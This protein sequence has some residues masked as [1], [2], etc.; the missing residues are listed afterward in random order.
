M[1]CKKL[2][3]VI[4]ALAVIG[5]AAVSAADTRSLQHAD[6]LNQTDFLLKGDSPTAAFDMDC[7]DKVNAMDLVM[8]KRIELAENVR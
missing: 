6:F 1:K 4:C 7:N 2:A 3:A 5:A 8:M